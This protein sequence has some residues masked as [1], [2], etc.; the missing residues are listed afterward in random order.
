MEVGFS[1]HIILSNL[2]FFTFLKIQGG[3]IQWGVSKSIFLMKY[4]DFQSWI[5]Y[6]IDFQN[7]PRDFKIPPGLSKSPLGFQNPPWIL[8]NTTLDF[9]KYPPG[10]SKFHKIH[11]G[12]S[13][14]RGVFCEILH[15]CWKT[16]SLKWDFLEPNIFKKFLTSFF[17][18]P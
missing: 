10:F 15:F 12:I 17:Y 5:E 8:K 3:E 1:L 4:L 18:H 16:Q 14:S 9:Q 2:Q 11:G 7:P 13:K 6:N